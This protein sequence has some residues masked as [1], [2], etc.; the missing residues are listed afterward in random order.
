MDQGPTLYSLPPQR[1][2]QEYRR[3][4]RSEYLP[5]RDNPEL[6]SGDGSSIVVVVVIVIVFVRSHPITVRF[7]W[8]VYGHSHGKAGVCASACALQL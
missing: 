4:L 6:P 2:R 7:I 8:F 5:R 1:P 3:Q